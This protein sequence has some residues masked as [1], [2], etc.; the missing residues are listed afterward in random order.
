VADARV[1]KRAAFVLE[2]TGAGGGAGY[3]RIASYV[4]QAT[5]TLLKAEFFS[6][7]ELRKVLAADVTTLVEVEPWWLILG[8]TIEN[9]RSGTSTALSLSNVYL[10]E[11]LPEELFD[12]A[13]F[14]RVTP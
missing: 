5:C 13:S 3:S 8:Y 10:R 14:Y 9:R 7:T 4:D 1:F 11:H 12:P 6:G 2:V